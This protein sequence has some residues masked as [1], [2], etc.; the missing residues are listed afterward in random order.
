MADKGKQGF[1]AMDPEERRELA[2]KGGH[3]S[4][5]GT[6][7][8]GDG[9]DGKDDRASHHGHAAFHHKTAAHHHRQAA[10]HHSA[11]NHEEA[12]R[13][14]HAAH[15]HSETAHEHS[16]RG[17]AAMDP[18]RVREI[19]RMGGLASHG[20]RGNQ[21]TLDEGEHDGDDITD[22][23]SARGKQGA[24]TQ[25]GTPEQ[26]AEAGRK[27]GQASHGDASHKG[28]DDDEADGQA[29][30]VQGGTPEQHSKAGKQGHKNS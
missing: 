18:E 20:G 2:R 17:F 29:V 10:R 23:R 30:G 3:N 4:H 5:G 8:E 22:Q 19:A 21:A 14:T 25:G 13:H 12:D 11:G 1:A 7:H 27:G 6:S 16:K 26:H 28:K 15:G 9:G 24:G